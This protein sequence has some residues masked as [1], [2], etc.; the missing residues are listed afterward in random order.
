MTKKEW[1]E[2][3]PFKVLIDSGLKSSMIAH[4]YVPSIDKTPNRASTLSKKLVTDLLQKGSST[5][6]G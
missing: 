3:Y 6:R 2:L 4:L 1:I 5:L